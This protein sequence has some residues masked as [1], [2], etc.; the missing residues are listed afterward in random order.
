MN[1]QIFMIPSIVIVIIAIF[2]IARTVSASSFT[3]GSTGPAVSELQAM[4]IEN[5]F[6]IPLL[7][8]GKAAFGYYGKQTDSAYKSYLASQNS[9]VLGAVAGTDVYYRTFFYSGITQ[10]GRVATSSTATT[11]TTNVKDFLNTPAVVAWTP[12]INTTVSISATS[13]FNYV[14]R[15]GDVAKVW[16]QNASTTAASSITF[17][18]ADS[19][20][21]LQTTEATGGDLVLNGLDWAE[22]TFIR[23][24]ATKVTVIFNEFIEA[25]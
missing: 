22:F 13:T 7:S 24:S 15:V 19:G 2:G 16:L 9:T 12:N 6:D 3:I 20:V 17:A 1:R 21:D 11:Y 25:D 5:G 10:G 14:P 18:A 4:L 8:N 23:Q